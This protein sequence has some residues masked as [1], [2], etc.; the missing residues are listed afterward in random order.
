MINELLSKAIESVFIGIEQF[1][2]KNVNTPVTHNGVD[3]LFVLENTVYGKKP[4]I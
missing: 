1:V 2:M 3:G 4:K